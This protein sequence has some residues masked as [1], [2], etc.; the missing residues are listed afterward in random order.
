MEPQPGQEKPHL[1]PPSLWP[2]GFAIGVVCILV[3]LI[4]SWPAAAVGVV[5]TVIFGFL[6]VRDVTT[7]YR[8]R[9]VGME[10]AVGGPESAT[11]GAPTIAADRGEAAM[12]SG[13][14]AAGSS[15]RR[16]SASAA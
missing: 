16:R 9:D 4:V 10:P 13:S 3:G 2:I 5:L 11:E 15:R 8:R 7:G 14:R 1:P 12:A 6:W